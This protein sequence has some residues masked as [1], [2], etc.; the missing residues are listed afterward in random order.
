SGTESDNLALLGT[1]RRLYGSWDFL[2]SAAEH[3]AV[4]MQKDALQALGHRVQILPLTPEGLLDLAAAE[5]ALSERTAL[6]SLMQVSN[7]TGAVQPL[8]ALAG[9]I[10]AK[11]PQ[12]LLHVDGVQGFLR[13]PM[14]LRAAHVDLYT[15]SGHKIHGPK[16]IGALA[17][18][19][20]AKLS[21]VLFGGGQERG[22]R[23]G[24]ENL[25]AI[26]GLDEAVRAMNALENP[27]A[28]MRRQKL[29]IYRALADGIPGL[30]VNGPAPDS[31][32]AAPHILNLSL[33]GI[34]GEVMVHALEE[35]GVLVGTGS[36][37]SSKKRKRSEGFASMNVSNERADSAVRIS[38]S[39]LTT[40]A[41]I[42]QAVEAFQACYA[43]LKP[44]Q[45][46]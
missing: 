29:A 16:G 4:L 5:E 42:G 7:E 32:Q 12:A 9:L 17:V 8:E 35:K 26:L 28:S 45:R 36:A 19:P 11:A 23:S 20:R 3:P 24:T 34:R 38:L 40:D 1:S 39:P 30:A 44:Y 37:C 13:L 18:G 41:E 21:P 31:P 2:I 46:R 15:L 33:P 27:S 14:S 10:R 25:P 22:L 6:V 43:L